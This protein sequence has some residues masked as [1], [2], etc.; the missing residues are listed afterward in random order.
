MLFAKIVAIL[1]QLQC[2]KLIINTLHAEL[3]EGNAN[4]S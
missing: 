2:V 4:I 3:F 1:S